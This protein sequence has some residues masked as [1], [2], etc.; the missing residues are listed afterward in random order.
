M[1]SLSLY[2]MDETQIN[3][4]TEAE[5]PTALLDIKVDQYI[6]PFILVKSAQGGGNTPLSSGLN[7]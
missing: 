3:M 4:W 1:L 7:S 6:E 2:K 5:D